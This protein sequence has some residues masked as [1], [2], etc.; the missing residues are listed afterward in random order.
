MEAGLS[1]RRLLRDEEG[2]EEARR[3]TMWNARTP[4]RYPDMIVRASNEQDVVAAVRL[5]G[6]EGMKIAVRSG[7][8]SWAGNHLRDGGMLLDLSGLVGASV[9]P[10]ALSAS[11]APACPGTALL[12]Q[13]AEHDLFFPGGHCV[14][15]ALGGYLLQGGFGW[16][17]RVHG[18]ACQSVEA[19]DVVTAAGELVRANAESHS[20]LYWAARGSGPGF[21]GVVTRFHVRVYPRPKV[22]AIGVHTYRLELLEDV[23]RWAHE[24]GPRIPRTMELML[25][26]HRDDAGEV[27]IAVTAPVLVDT[28]DEAREA[29]AL[30]ETCPVLEEAKIS[31]PMVAVS[32]D[33]LFAG[34][35]AIYPDNHR[36]VTDNMWTHAPVEE[37]LPGLHRIAET[38]P[39][40][41]S[42]MLWMNW[43]A[44]PPRQDMAY[45]VEDETYIACYA[46]SPGAD[47]DRVNVD[48]STER[49]RELEHLSTGIQLADE[50]LG[51]RAARFVSDE[52]LRRLDRVRAVYDPDG[53]FHPWMGRPGVT[54]R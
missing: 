20:D 21:F 53:L 6:S 41:P 1:R 30:L 38:L 29:L 19:I 22:M 34:S 4:E 32:F 17:G 33:D 25:L 8:H 52:N 14:G 3:A 49:M 2:Y 9:D 28:E 18:P 36:W 47:A 7:G 12:A 45:S 54:D 50:N 5:A 46:A 43:G 13:L 16:N 10:A 51:R 31:V 48:W 40:A 39:G 44:S 37:L 24:I 15:V 26:I 11:I 42:H 27:E 23:F 35:A